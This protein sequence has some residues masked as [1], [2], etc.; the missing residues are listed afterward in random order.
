LSLVAEFS[1]LKEHGV[2][3]IYHL[4]EQPFESEGN[5][6]YITRPNLLYTKWIANHVKSKNV[7]HSIFFVPQRT[8]ICDRVLEE[9]G[10]LGDVTIGEYYLDVINLEDDLLSLEMP[11]SFRDFYL[12]VLADGRMAI[13]QLYRC[14]RMP[15]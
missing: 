4:S 5:L 6:L 1:I 7:S 10:V 9:E 13:G 2:E 14:S 12:V 15:S 8:L 3:K 11:T